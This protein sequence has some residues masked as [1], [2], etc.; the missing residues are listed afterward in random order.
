MSFVVII[1]FTGT[2]C[3]FVIS[4]KQEICGHSIRFLVSLEPK[5]NEVKWQI[6]KLCPD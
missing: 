1:L 2:I 4:S 6:C 5:L 3:T